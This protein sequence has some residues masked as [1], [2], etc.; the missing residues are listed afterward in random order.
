MKPR[1]R[2]PQRRPSP[3]V[4]RVLFATDFSAASAPA[5]K[6]SLALARANGARLRIVHVVPPLALSHGA[7][8]AYAEM[9]SEIRHDAWRRL[10]ALE[11]RA[12]AAGVR[13]ESLLLRGAPH[14]AVVRAARAMRNSWI[15]IGTHGRTGLSGVFL[16]SV[17][18]R[19]VAMAPCPVL[20][21]RGSKPP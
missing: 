7:R 3:V 16:G 19:I 6:R 14:E 10:R 15:V 1:R 21:V 13:A 17:A 20:T 4:R 12:A 2:R 9:E 5:W 18:A 8:W 11:R